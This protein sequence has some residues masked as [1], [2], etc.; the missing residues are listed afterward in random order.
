MIVYN[1]NEFNMPVNENGEQ[2]KLTSF[3][4]FDGKKWYEF[5]SEEERINFINEK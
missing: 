5:E 3:P 2:I 1:I 4:H